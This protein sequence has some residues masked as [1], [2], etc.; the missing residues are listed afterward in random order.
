MA[1]AE[2][3]AGGVFLK[4]EEEIVGEGA[5]LA[6]TAGGVSGSEEVVEEGCDGNEYCIDFFFFL[7]EVFVV[8]LIKAVVCHILCVLAEIR[9][10]PPPPLMMRCWAG[11]WA[12]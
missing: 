10:I 9:I 5:R 12:K 1:R 3:V 11:C 7:V 6:G 2:F 4:Y 8:K